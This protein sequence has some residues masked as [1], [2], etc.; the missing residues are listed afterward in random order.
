M[1]NLECVPPADRVAV[2][3]AFQIP[4]SKFL[5]HEPLLPKEGGQR[6]CHHGLSGLVEM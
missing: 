2:E 3:R 6:V 5:I 1:W 4:L